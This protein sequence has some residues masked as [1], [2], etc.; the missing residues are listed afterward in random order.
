MGVEAGGKNLSSV[1]LSRLA[2]GNSFESCAPTTI[3]HD[4]WLAKSRFV[5]A[6]AILNPL[7]D[8]AGDSTTTA[9]TSCPCLPV[10]STGH[11]QSLAAQPMAKA[12]PISAPTTTSLSIFNSLALFL[13]I[14]NDLQASTSYSI[15]ASR[16]C[17]F[18]SDGS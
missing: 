4:N 10:A 17:L 7:N 1:C 18:S 8:Q 15:I 3:I 16:S 9:L 14:R 11:A 13:S 6:G 2:S 12:A 5:A